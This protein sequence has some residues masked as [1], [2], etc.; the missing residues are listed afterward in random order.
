MT[1]RELI[2]ARV[3]QAN[4]GLKSAAESPLAAATHAP[5]TVNA[6]G[7]LERF[8]EVAKDYRASLTL[9]P[10]AEIAEAI[11]K[12]CAA[13]SATTMALP[14]G[15]PDA[16]LPKGIDFISANHLEA[17]DLGLLQG[18]LSTC[19]L[20]IAETGTLVLD[21]G[22]GQGMRA[23]SLI[24]DYHLC[25]L[26]QNQIVSSVPE[27]VAALAPAVKAGRPLTFI[28]GPSATSDIELIRVEGVHG[29]RTLDILITL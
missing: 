6:Q 28:S 5:P 1:S 10:E 8:I 27:A 16:W 11:A 20:A 9:V 19:A 3:R 22:P 23:L 4:A 13:Q 26:Q 21:G 14:Q 15:F 12:C 25:L 17:H 29:P 18:T 2:L 7:V 24:P